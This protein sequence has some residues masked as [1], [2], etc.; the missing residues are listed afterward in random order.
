MSRIDRVKEELRH[1]VS[2]IVG[3]ELHDTR[4]GFVTITRVEVTPD[5][6]DAKIY[7][8]TMNTGE[9]FDDTQG[10]LDRSAKYVRKLIGERMR[11]K[12]TPMIRFIYD[13]P[14]KISKKI[15][16]IIDKIHKEKEA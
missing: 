2:M 5:L 4:I 11:I 3:Q 7:F 15:D 1:Q 10:C 14:Q 13:E 16:E 8:T 9:A 12:F 6:K